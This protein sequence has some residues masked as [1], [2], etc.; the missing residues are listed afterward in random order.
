MLL[1]NNVNADY[2]RNSLIYNENGG[3]P[4]SGVGPY[5]IIF[6]FNIESVAKYISEAELALHVDDINYPDEQNIITFIEPDGTEHSLGFL[7]TDT[8]GKTVVHLSLD[9]SW[10]KTGT[11]TI[12]IDVKPGWNASVDDAKL[13]IKNIIWTRDIEA[14]S[15]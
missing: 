14:A 9:P 7:E 6:W 13:L 3:L 12:R 11:N 15:E 5:E 4:D 10:I 2:E 8:S 1:T